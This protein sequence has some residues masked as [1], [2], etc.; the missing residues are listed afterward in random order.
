LEYELRKKLNLGP[1]KS[2]AAVMSKLIRVD[3]AWVN[4]TEISGLIIVRNNVAHKIG[5][6]NY[7]E[8]EAKEVLESVD[9]ILG[10]LDVLGASTIYE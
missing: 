2:F 7:G 10:H 1:N 5:S 6:V 4:S 3:L 8:K 9:R